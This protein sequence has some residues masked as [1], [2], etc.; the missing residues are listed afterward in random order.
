MKTSITTILWGK[1]HTLGEFR[2]VLTEVRKIGYDGIGLETR[3]LSLEMIK[4]PNLVKKTLREAGVENSGS[5]STMKLQ[6]V[7]WASQAG[8]PILWVVARGDKS[9]REALGVIREL[10][11]R[12]AKSGIA[13]ALHNHLGTRFETEAQ[14]RKALTQVK[15]LQVCFDTAHA[16]AADFDTPGFI[17]DFHERIALVHVKDLRVK[18]PKARVSFTKDFV[19]AGEGILNFSKIVGALKDSGYDGNLMLET[20]VIVGRR[21]GEV[22]K[23]GYDRIQ[24]L[25]REA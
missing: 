8:T 18:V 9:F 20:E 2:K 12:A 1:I 11:S 25:L 13:I 7:D 6:D 5:Y 23:E 16:E 21:P 4:D 17:R 15:G 24:T 19:N 3:L 10:K 22:A 14:M